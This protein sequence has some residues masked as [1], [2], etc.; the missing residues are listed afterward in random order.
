MTLTP[1]IKAATKQGFFIPNKE[2]KYSVGHNAGMKLDASGGIGIHISAEQPE[3]VPAE[4][5]LPINRENLGLDVIMRVYVPD[6]EKMK[7]WEAPIAEKSAHSRSG[8]GSRHL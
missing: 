1:G 4:N 5:W 6:L 8:V 7:T 2:K 3:G